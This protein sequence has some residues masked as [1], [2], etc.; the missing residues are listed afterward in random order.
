V[1]VD[2]AQVTVLPVFK[3]LAQQGG[4]AEL[5]LLRTFNCGVGMVAIVRGEAVDQ[6]ADVLTQA[7]ERVAL[8]GEVIAA[9]DNRVIYDN[10]L[11]LAI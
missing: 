4:L 2:L 11:D 9:A 5:E 8:L 3:W 1:R 6:V 7:G 10:H